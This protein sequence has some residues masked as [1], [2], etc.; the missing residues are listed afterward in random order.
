LIDDALEGL[1]MPMSLPIASTAPSETSR[2]LHD[3][4]AASQDLVN[5]ATRALARAKTA[6]DERERTAPLHANRNVALG[7]LTDIIH[8]SKQQIAEGKAMLEQLNNTLTHSLEKLRNPSFSGV[9]AVDLSN[10]CALYRLQH[11]PAA[12]QALEGS[13][14]DLLGFSVDG[15][16]VHTNIGLPCV[17]DCLR[18]HAVLNCAQNHQPFPK[19]TDITSAGDIGNPRTW[20]LQ[21]VGEWL[22]RCQL[23][24]FIEPFGKHRVAG[25]VLDSIKSFVS[26]IASDTPAARR[27]ALLKAIRELT[28]NISPDASQQ[29]G[30]LL[31]PMLDGNDRDE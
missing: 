4:L 17:G 22:Q 25:D 14:A 1:G 16:S 20:S 31:M 7:R 30:Y 19:A 11:E 10:V 8:A 24:E 12:I 27:V 23:D 6:F 21:Q 18:L 5:R 28:V 26:S 13:V 3:A 15:L 2:L 9:S 29:Q